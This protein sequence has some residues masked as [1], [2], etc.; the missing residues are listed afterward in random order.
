MNYVFQKRSHINT[1]T[2]CTHLEEICNLLN[3]CRPGGGGGQ[4]VRTN[5]PSFKGSHL[6]S[7]GKTDVSMETPSQGDTGSRCEDSGITR[8]LGAGL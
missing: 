7:D 2:L 4:S 3:F 6:T 8:G 1:R 5:H